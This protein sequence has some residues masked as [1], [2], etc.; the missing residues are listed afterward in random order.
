MVNSLIYGRRCFPIVPKLASLHLGIPIY[1][2]KRPTTLLGGLTSFGGAG[3]NYSMHVCGLRYSKPYEI[4]ELIK[5]G[6]H[7]DGA[8]APAGQWPYRPR[9]RQWR[10]SVASP[11][12]VS[13]STTTRRL[14]P[15]SEPKSSSTA[16]Q[17]CPTA[18]CRE[19]PG[20]CE[21]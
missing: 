15:L 9:P 5:I 4:S 17:R 11:C 8:P 21:D 7:G 20:E 12:S 13:V 10:R 6:N 1:G 14:C 3:N 19:C 18:Y 16:C 2:G